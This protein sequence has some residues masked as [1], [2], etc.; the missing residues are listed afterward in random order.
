[1]IYELV[2]IWENGEKSIEEFKN[3]EEAHKAANNYK[4]AFG[5]QVTWTGI[6]PKR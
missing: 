3:E 5:H 4:M 2:I 6:R 1:M